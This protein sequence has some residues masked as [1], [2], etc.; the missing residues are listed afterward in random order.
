MSKCK[1]KHNL[2]CV[3]WVDADQQSGW[4]EYD[5]KEPLWIMHTYGLLV[6]KTKHWVVLADTHLP[7]DSWGGL[8]KIPRRSVKKIESIMRSAT[9]YRELPVVKDKNIGGSSDEPPVEPPVEPSKGFT[10]P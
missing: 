1:E 10:A 4:S 2:V 5:P 3:E 9:C 6:D 7:P 8:N